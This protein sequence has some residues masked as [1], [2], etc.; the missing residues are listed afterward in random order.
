ME[1]RIHGREAGGLD[2]RDAFRL[3]AGAVQEELRVA[4]AAGEITDEV[5]TV[6]LHPPQ[7]AKAQPAV[8]G[9]QAT[10]SIRAYRRKTE[11]FN[12]VQFVQNLLN[13][14]FALD[15]FDDCID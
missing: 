4:A 12:R 8:V 13:V 10:P 7:N 14:F 6:H 11:Q 9:I 2:H 15:F 3:E 1:R 5:Q